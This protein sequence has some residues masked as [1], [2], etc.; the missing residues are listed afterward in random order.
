MTSTETHHAAG[1]ASSTDVPAIATWL[2]TADHKQV[3]RLFIGTGLLGLL[4]GL[5]L[6]VLVAF[7][8]IDAEGFQLL[9]SGSATQ[10]LSAARLLL[11]FG[12]VA[13]LVMGLAVAIVPLQLGSR[14]IAFPRVA[15][16]GFWMWLTGLVLSVAAIIGNGGPSGGESEMVDLYLAASVVMVLGLA[17]AALSIAVTGLTS[18]APGMGLLRAPFFS[19]SSFVGSIA[20][21]MSLPVFIG[22]SVY[23]YV[24]HRYARAAFG[25]NFGVNNWVGWAISQP[26]T[27][28]LAI[29][30]LGFVLD[31]VPVLGRTRLAQ[32]PAANV[33]VGLVSVAI[34][35]SLTHRAVT[36]PWEGDGFFSGLGTKIADLLPFGLVNVIPLFGL[37]GVLGLT[38]LTLKSA[39]PMLAAP[40]PFAVLGLLMI[41]LGA[42]SH[43]L[44]T[45][46]DAALG[47][48]I[49]EAGSY[50]AVTFGTVLLAFGGLT[51]WGPKLWGRRIPDKAALPLALLGFVAAALGSLPYMVAGF[52]DQ[53]AGIV[54]G[55]AYSGPQELWNVVTTGA[56]AL[57]LLVSLAFVGLAVRSFTAGEAAGDDPWDGTTLEWATSS[58]PPADNFSDLIVVGSE[59]P[60]A[61][62]KNSGKVG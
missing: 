34:F 59:Y 32:R 48:T 54:D 14:S 41:L 58:P 15:A 23:L 21:L 3:G 10:V 50:V 42:A 18:R 40:L 20:L 16:S 13:P 17:M 52:A 19:W 26:F 4:G 5:V 57:M 33:A 51:Y 43:L 38:M 30:V 8:R 47:G 7:E 49:F 39:K 28:V 27:Y 2:T 35:A 62:I 29:P 61:D 36:L 25:G 12:A 44:Y 60:L 11:T 22:T 37:L 24:D 56:F 31:A 45:V 1:A 46:E 9:D 55:F 6:A 53:P